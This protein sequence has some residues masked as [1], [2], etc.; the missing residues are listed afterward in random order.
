MERVLTQDIKRANGTFFGRKGDV[1]DY[2]V[3]TWRNI[4]KSVLPKVSD[5]M[6]AL[7][8]ISVPVDQVGALMRK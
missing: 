4:A 7:N 8:K 6:S 2:P 3:Y 5:V 1:K